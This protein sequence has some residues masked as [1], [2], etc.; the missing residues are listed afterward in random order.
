MWWMR[1]DGKYGWSGSD[2]IINVMVGILISALIIG[3]LYGIYMVIWGV[4]E[5]Y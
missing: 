5:E 1:R 2:M 4:Y 3:M